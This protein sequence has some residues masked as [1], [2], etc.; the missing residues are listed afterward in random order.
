MLD[1]ENNMDISK[2][3]KISIGAVLQNLKRRLNKCVI[4]QL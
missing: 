4:K 3:V 2:S 1:N